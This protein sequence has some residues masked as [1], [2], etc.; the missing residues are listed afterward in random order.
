MFVRL[1]GLTDVR[2]PHFGSLFVV[3]L[4]V[5]FIWNTEADNRSTVSHHVVWCC[6]VFATT[7]H[8]T[9]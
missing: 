2:V 9:E 6:V 1:M 7:S 5:F 4:L 3:L 8:S